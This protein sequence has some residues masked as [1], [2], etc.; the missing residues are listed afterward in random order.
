M[1][2][3]KLVVI[4][5]LLV[6]FTNSG[7]SLNAIDNNAMSIDVALEAEA[8]S[9]GKS[10]KFIEYYENK[11][12]DELKIYFS[13]EEIDLSIESIEVDQLFCRA[14][15]QVQSIDD[16]KVKECIEIFEQQFTKYE[17]WINGVQIDVDEFK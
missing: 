4:L 2:S 8:Y 10:E 9:T 14:F 7:C 6:L 11:L 15:I 13:T 16:A 12:T 5:L 17:L 3:R 1:S